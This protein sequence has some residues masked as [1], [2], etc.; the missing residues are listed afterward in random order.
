MPPDHGAAVVKIILQD[1]TL[2]QQWHDELSSMTA[3]IKS[4]RQ[5]MADSFPVLGFVARQKGLFSLLPLNPAQ[6]NT[7]I[8]EH[9]VYLAGDGRINIAGCQEHQ[10]ERFVAALKAVDFCGTTP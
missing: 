5:S 1:N 10:I 3:R 4:L 9:A 7:L 6:V 2:R 8:D